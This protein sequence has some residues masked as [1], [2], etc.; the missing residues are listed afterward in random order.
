MPI[1]DPLDGFFYPTLTLMIYSYNPSGICDEGAGLVAKFYIS[2][3]P[4][5]KKLKQHIALCLLVLLFVRPLQKLSYSFE[6]LLIDLSS[7]K[8]DPYFLPR[9]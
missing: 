2:M 9:C 5:L 1:G 7:K 8:V 3:P 6:I 4:T